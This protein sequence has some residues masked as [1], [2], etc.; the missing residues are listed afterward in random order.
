MI[1][2]KD[3]GDN[4]DV[5]AIKPLKTAIERFLVPRLPTAGYRCV[6]LQDRKTIYLLFAAKS[7]CE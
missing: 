7:K 3:L 6:M 4:T 1:T 5:A 2:Q